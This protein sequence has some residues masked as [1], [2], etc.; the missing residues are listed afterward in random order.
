MAASN[1]ELGWQ[2]RAK[3]KRDAVLGLIPEEWRI[4]VPSAQEQRD[5]TGKYVCQY[6]T[7]KEVEITETVAESIVEKTSTGKWSAEEVARAFA[8]RA[9]LAH[10]LVGYP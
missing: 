2:Q 10:Q 5:V 7:D 1:S 8:H 9:A 4:K 3:A 6:L